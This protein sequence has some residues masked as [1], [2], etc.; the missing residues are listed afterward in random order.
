VSVF[1]I[2]SISNNEQ[3]TIAHEWGFA[4]LLTRGWRLPL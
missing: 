4:L 1:M 2:N 3:A